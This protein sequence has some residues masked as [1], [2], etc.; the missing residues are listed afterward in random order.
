MKTPGELGRLFEQIAQPNAQGC[1]QVF[2][3][4]ELAADYDEGFKTTNG[5]QW[6]RKNSYLGKKYCI[7]KT[8]NRGRLDTIQLDGFVGAQ[9]YHAI[10]QP[11]RDFYKGRTCVFTGSNDRIEIDHKDARYSQNYNDIS[12]FQPVCKAMNDIKREVC[13]KC[14]NTNCR[15]KGSLLGFPYDFLKGNENSNYCEG[16]YYYDPIQFRQG[17]SK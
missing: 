17:L 14:K 9:E 6:S 8:Y 1:S 10:P 7:K 15:P 4:E 13:K 16:C 12:A 3:V 5:S 11:V 2:S